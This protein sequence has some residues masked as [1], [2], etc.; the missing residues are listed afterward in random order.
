MSCGLSA[1]SH[2]V[3]VQEP[4]HAPEEAAEGSKRMQRPPAME[5]HVM[6]Y[7][8]I[9]MQRSQ[10]QKIVEAG[11]PG[12]SDDKAPAKGLSVSGRIRLAPVFS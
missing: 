9:G 8:K 6:T 11:S 10:R 3:S 5:E 12:R 7:L 1:R 4:C 2:E